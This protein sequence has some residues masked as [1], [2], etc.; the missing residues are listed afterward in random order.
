MLQTLD[1]SHN[2]FSGSYHVITLIP[3]LVKVNLGY[4][5]LFAPIETELANLN[6]VE[7]LRLGN[8]RLYGGFPFV[9]LT[10]NSGIRCLF[11][12]SSNNLTGTI[13]VVTGSSPT[14]IYMQ[15]NYLNGSLSAAFWTATLSTVD[16][17]NNRLSGPLPTD[18]AVSSNLVHFDAGFNSLSGT[19][20]AALFQESIDYINFQN[21]RFNG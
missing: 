7:E 16:V 12:F 17:S 13:P 14:Y 2:A 8:N 4:N 15:N 11:D 18:V 21:K 19:L 10:C 3:S 20:P 5:Q 9:E 1:A 6:A